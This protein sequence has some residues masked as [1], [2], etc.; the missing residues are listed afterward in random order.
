[1]MQVLYW[2]WEST[3]KPGFKIGWET[4]FSRQEGGNVLSNNLE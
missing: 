3:V 1:M 2:I 4:D